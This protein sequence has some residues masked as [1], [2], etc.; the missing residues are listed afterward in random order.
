M[1]DGH[2]TG[3]VVGPIVDRARKAA[4]LAEVAAAEG[5]LLEQTVAIGDGANDLDMLAAAGLG[6]AFNAKPVVRAAADTALSFPYL[7][8]ILFVLGVRRE[9]VE[10]ADEADPSV[11]KNGLIP[12]PGTPPV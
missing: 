10:A 12:V 2:L 7:D 5:V 1:V 8:A 6:I 3:R 4:V 9:D 11:E